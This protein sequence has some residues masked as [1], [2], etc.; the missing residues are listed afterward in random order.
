MHTKGRISF[1]ILRGA[2]P[3][4]SVT[5]TGPIFPSVVTENAWIIGCYDRE[6]VR[7][8]DDETGQWTWPDIQTY[9][10]SVNHVTCSILG[11]QS[12]I[13]AQ[14]LDGGK[15]IKELIEKY[16]KLVELANKA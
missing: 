4:W 2:S 12:T 8:L 5:T 15:E 13:P 16:G 6:K 10:A 9:G 7:V 11:I 1:G 3:S 14:V